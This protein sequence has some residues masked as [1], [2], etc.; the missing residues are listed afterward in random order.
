MLQKGK[1][2]LFLRLIQTLHT[3][4]V[5]STEHCILTHPLFLPSQVILYSPEVHN[6]TWP[7]YPSL[8]LC[9]LRYNKTFLRFINLYQILS[10]YKVTIFFPL[11]KSIFSHIKSTMCEYV[12]LNLFQQITTTI[13]W[14][15][16]F[17]FCFQ[18]AILCIT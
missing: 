13:I 17:R 3:I 5:M 8:L 11:T 1:R 7:S 14:L 12:A 10:N 4:N 6:C 9:I 2:H 18:I 16:M 15:H